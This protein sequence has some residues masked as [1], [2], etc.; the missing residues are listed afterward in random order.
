LEIL[1]EIHQVDGVTGNSYIIVRD[2]LTII[3]TG[4]PGNSTKIFTCITK[5]LNRQLSDVGTIILTHYHLDHTGD[6]TTIK[7][8]IPGAKVAVHAAEAAYIAGR[9]PIPQSKEIGV[10]KRIRKLFEKR[11]FLEPD[12]L[13]Q[14]GDRIAGLVVIHIPGHTPGSLGLL[15]EKTRTFFAGDVFRYDGKILVEGPEE[16]TRDRNLEQESIRR[17]ATIDI[18]ILLVGHGVPLKPGA[19]EEIRAFALT[20]PV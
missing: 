20:L 5:T 15:D 10:L 13:L 14:D 11:E 1:P 3:D 6:I 8:A 17:I 2:T 19:Q 16:H 9:V 4:R 18:E 7:K 12:I